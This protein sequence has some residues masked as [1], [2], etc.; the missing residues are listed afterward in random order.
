MIRTGVLYYGATDDRLP[1]LANKPKYQRTVF[2]PSRKRVR[3]ATTDK[4]YEAR[5]PYVAVLSDNRQQGVETNIVN[6][7]YKVCIYRPTYVPS[8]P[9]YFFHI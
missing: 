9:L 5:A 7:Q 4:L 6:V 3:T 2:E 1:L 8:Y